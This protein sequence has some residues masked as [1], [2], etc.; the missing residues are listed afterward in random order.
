M[1]Y[2]IATTHT[3]KDLVVVDYGQ[4]LSLVGILITGDGVQAMTQL[5]G[6]TLVVF[7]YRQILG[8]MVQSCEWA[9][10]R[11]LCS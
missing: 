2:A 1:S 4:G 11:G 3:E 6:Q 5:G 9:K 10:L 8:V 7:D